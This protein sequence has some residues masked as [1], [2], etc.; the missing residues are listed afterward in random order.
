MT[1]DTRVDPR[2]ER[3][4]KLL[5]E[6]LSQLI[7]ERGY[8]SIT[9]QDITERA[10]VSRTTFYLHYRT[11]DELLISSFIDLYQTLT[12]KIPEFGRENFAQNLLDCDASDYEHVAEHA[13][14]YR[15]MLSGRGSMVFLLA[16]MAYLQRVFQDDALTPLL[17][18]PEVGE[19]RLPL[20]FISAFLAGSEV[21]VMK[22]WLDNDLKP[23]PEEMARMHFEMAAYG[24]SRALRLDEDTE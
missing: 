7:I 16:V 19:P 15:A 18:P 12:P 4:K 1:T 22:W 11:K 9:I 24:I 21:G 2:I 23:A 6:A 5:R 20:D 8:D 10:N 3:T 14:F 17:P 13:E